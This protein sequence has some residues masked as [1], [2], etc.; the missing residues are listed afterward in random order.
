MIRMLEDV[1]S[2]DEN[3]LILLASFFGFSLERMVLLT[4]KFHRRFLWGVETALLP[5]FGIT[6]TSAD[7]FYLYILGDCSIISLLC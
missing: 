6:Q 3:G 2:H 7:L 1:F 4:L 5:V